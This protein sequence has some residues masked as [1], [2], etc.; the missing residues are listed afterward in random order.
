MS[1]PLTEQPT[2]GLREAARIAID[3]YETALADPKVLIPTPLHAAMHRLKL[4]MEPK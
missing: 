2:E 3:C 4:A 1:A